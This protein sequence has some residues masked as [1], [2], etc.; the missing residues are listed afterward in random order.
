MY[1]QCTVYCNKETGKDSNLSVGGDLSTLCK[2]WP[3]K[4]FNSSHLTIYKM[5]ELQS[6]SHSGLGLPMPQP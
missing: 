1:V 4:A 2:F 3:G 6:S 5:K